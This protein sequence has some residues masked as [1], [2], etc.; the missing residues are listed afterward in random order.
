MVDFQTMKIVRANIS[1]ADR[2]AK[3]H[4]KAW[5][6]AYKDLIPIE[7]LNQES[8]RKRKDEFINNQ[9]EPFL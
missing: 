7:Y 5:I 8:S 4:S 1:H 6:Q 3:I 2:Y 9:Q